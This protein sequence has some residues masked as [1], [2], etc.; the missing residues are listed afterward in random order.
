[1]SSWT[2]KKKENCLNCGRTVYMFCEKSQKISN[3]IRQ[4]R[5]LTY[6]N[7]EAITKSTIFLSETK[8]SPVNNVSTDDLSQSFKY[9][10]KWYFIQNFSNISFLPNRQYKDYWRRAE[11]SW[12]L[13]KLSKIKR[14]THGLVSQRSTKLWQTIG[15]LIS[16][17]SASTLITKIN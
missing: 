15:I 6:I 9:N 10:Y 14:D 12:K 17:R 7:E 4:R 1:M 11:R 5:V 2:C 13:N 16:Q 3:E 8:K